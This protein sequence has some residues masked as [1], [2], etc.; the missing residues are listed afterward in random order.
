MTLT[1]W[2]G[3]SPPLPIRIKK[4]GIFHIE[5]PGKISMGDIKMVKINMEKISMG[6]ISM[7]EVNMSCLDIKDIAQNLSVL[8]IKDIAP[9]SKSES[10]TIRITIPISITNVRSIVSTSIS[11]CGGYVPEQVDSKANNNH[12]NNDKSEINVSNDGVDE[13]DSN[14]NDISEK[15]INTFVA[16]HKRICFVC[17]EVSTL[18]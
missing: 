2:Y 17:K 15:K 8:S 18:R 11:D 12:V 4:N 1:A 16:N 13:D 14:T 5:K 3:G 6:G 10:A 7:R 9:P